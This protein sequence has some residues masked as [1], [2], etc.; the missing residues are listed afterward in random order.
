MALR[1]RFHKFRCSGMH[2]TLETDTQEGRK[3][4]AIMIKQFHTVEPIYSCTENK[5]SKIL[6]R[7][8]NNFKGT[9]NIVHSII[10]SSASLY[11]RSRESLKHFVVSN[12]RKFR[13]LTRN[14]SRSKIKTE[15]YYS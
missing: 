5:Y 1:I 4:F 11:L 2:V 3:N 8:K 13:A 9:I 6:T 12:E 10:T 15:T 7:S 14:K